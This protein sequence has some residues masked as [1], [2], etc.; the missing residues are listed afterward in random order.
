MAR[1]LVIEDDP[2]VRVLFDAILTRF[3]VEVVEAGHGQQALE[4]LDGKEEFDLILMDLMMPVMDGFSLLEQIASRHASLF[5]RIIVVTAASEKQIAQLDRFPLRVVLRKPFD[6]Q[7]LADAI[8]T[9]TQ[10]E[11]SAGEGPREAR[12]PARR[13]G[14]TRREAATK[15]G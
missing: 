13:M 8:G 15:T 10:D 1:A 14:P 3:G 6:L 2:G 7:H 9:L 5:D 11:V 4:R 12:K